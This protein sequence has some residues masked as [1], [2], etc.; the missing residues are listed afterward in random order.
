MSST[1][2]SPCKF[3]IFGVLSMMG[4]GVFTL[5]KLLKYISNKKR[6]LDLDSSEKL[7]VS[8]FDN[9]L[10]EYSTKFLESKVMEEYLPREFRNEQDL[11]NL[12]TN[13]RYSKGSNDIVN[14]TKVS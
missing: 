12:S 5:S 6:K 1:T 3:C 9:I 7:T 14:L 8:D 11:L 2:D 10:K 13:M 4:V